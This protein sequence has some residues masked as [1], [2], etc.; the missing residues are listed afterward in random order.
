[1]A[2]VLI[3]N[4]EMPKE[5]CHHTLSIYSDGSVEIGRRN[6]YRAIELPPHG[7]LIDADAEI[8][9][10]EHTKIVLKECDQKRTFAF[11]EACIAAKV[12]SDAL[13]VLEASE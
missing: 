8:K 3:K 6:N 9:A 1:M 12:L 13:T 10:W 4:M 2:D 5:G 11:K 7:R